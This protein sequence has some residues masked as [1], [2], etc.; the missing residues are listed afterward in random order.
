MRILFLAS[1][2]VAVCGCN[3]GEATESRPA[4]LKA[5]AKGVNLSPDA[6]QWKYVELSDLRIFIFMDNLGVEP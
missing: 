6:P 5:D 3:K 4:A 1:V 2:W